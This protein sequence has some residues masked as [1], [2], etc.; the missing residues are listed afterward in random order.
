MRYHDGRSAGASGRGRHRFA[1]AAPIGGDRRAIEASSGVADEAGEF[2]V[3]TEII[4]SSGVFQLSPRGMLLTPSNEVIDLHAWRERIAPVM[5]PPI[6]PAV[7]RDPTVTS[8]TDAASF[9]TV[10]AIP[11]DQPNTTSAAPTTTLPGG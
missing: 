10:T 4:T 8:T 9:T 7:T 6:A 1:D 5:T 11:Q 3:V 2:G